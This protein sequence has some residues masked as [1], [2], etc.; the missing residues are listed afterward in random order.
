MRAVTSL[1][2]IFSPLP[3]IAPSAFGPVPTADANHPDSGW[4]MDHYPS[5]QK[6]TVSE[7]GAFTVRGD[8]RAY[9]VQDF[10]AGTD[11]G[12]FKYVRSDLQKQALKFTLDLS[13][14]D[15]GWCASSL[16]SHATWD[17]HVRGLPHAAS[18]ACIWSR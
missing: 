14:V 15:C 16:P 13:G 7:D 6:P 1:V 12:D 4:I 2:V 5:W 8:V 11:W 10:K 17:A 3:S 9:L 18:P